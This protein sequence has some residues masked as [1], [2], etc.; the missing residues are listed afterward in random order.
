[1]I[2]S[3][4]HSIKRVA[5]VEQK[6]NRSGQEE[7]SLLQAEMEEELAEELQISITTNEVIGKPVSYTHLDVYKRQCSHSLYLYSAI[8]CTLILSVHNTYF[9]SIQ[10]FL[11]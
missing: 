6:V 5:L 7:T 11:S 9:M 8:L 3:T 2:G 10:C 1:M 4:N